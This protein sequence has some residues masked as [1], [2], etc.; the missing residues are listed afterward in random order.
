MVSIKIKRK[1]NISDGNKGNSWKYVPK[2]SATWSATT[3]KQGTS[4]KQGTPSKQG[5][6]SK[7]GNLGSFKSIQIAKSK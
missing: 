7:Q 6:L 5:T 1:Q 3:S 2:F 4:S